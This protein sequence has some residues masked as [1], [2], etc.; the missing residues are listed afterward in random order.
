[1]LVQAVAGGRCRNGPASLDPSIRV[2]SLAGAVTQA[3]LRTH[4]RGRGAR[5]ADVVAGVVRI[6]L[7]NEANNAGSAWSCGGEGNVRPWGT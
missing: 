1:M 5:V 2:E 7:G 6:G 3:H 4:G